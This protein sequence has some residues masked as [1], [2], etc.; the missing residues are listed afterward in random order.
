[1]GN[2]GAAAMQPA[3]FRVG[4]GAS[5]GDKV[6][7]STPASSRSSSPRPPPSL[8]TA[9][10]CDDPKACGLMRGAGASW[11]RSTAHV[12]ASNPPA[13]LP[14]SPPP[15][16]PLPPSPSPRGEQAR[17]SSQVPKLPF[18]RAS[19]SPKHGRGHGLARRGDAVWPA[20]GLAAPPRSCRAA[21]R[22][23]EG[24]DVA[25]RGCGATAPEAPPLRPPTALPREGQDSAYAPPI[26]ALAAAPCHN[27]HAAPA[28]AAA[29]REQRP[30][31][32]IFSPNLRRIY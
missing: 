4:A 17:G 22:L 15:P 3:G 10:V 27:G 12:G 24:L 26:R 16:F 13:C 25:P 29:R 8:P 30:L 6:S 7:S 21:P 23:S 19:H 20:T 11:Q 2:H 28:H 31:R 1:M 14:P 9:Q 5:C 32:R 18:A